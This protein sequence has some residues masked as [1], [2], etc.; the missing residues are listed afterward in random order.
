M[1]ERF[2]FCRVA[3]KSSDVVCRNQQMT[4]LIEPD[5]ADPALTLLDEAAMAA[6]ITLQGVIWQ[7]FS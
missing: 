4:G 1:K 6:R 5:F 7:V 2:L 3:G